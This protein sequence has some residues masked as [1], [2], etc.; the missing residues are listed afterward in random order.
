MTAVKRLADK[1]KFSSII[2]AGDSEFDIPM[3][4]EADLSFIPDERLI[5]SCKGKIH[6]HTD[7]AL[8]FAEYILSEII[9]R[10]SL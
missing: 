8:S 6:I 1:Y 10:Y 3:L 7:T 9:S 5:D 4:R 2:C